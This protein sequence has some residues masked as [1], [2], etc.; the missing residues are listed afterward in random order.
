MLEKNLK[1]S[2]KKKKFVTRAFNYR[3]I[4]FK[5]DTILWIRMIDLIFQEE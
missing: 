5:L 2:F 4:S 1:S 3:I